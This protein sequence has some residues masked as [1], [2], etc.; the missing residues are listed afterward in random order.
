[1]MIKGKTKK[2][3]QCHLRGKNLSGDDPD[4][5]WE[6]EVEE[7]E[8]ENEDEQGEPTDHLGIAGT[9]GAL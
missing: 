3:R 5:G 9:K 4:V 6:A 2:W 1:M 8:V 7:D